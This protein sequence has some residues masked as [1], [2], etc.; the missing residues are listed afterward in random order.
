MNKNKHSKKA[1]DVLRE[2]KF[3]RKRNEF[4][5]FI[6]DWKDWKEYIMSHHRYLRDHY[7]DPELK[8]LGI[9]IECQG[10]AQK[11]VDKATRL[12][13]ETDREFPRQFARDAFGVEL[14][15]SFRDDL[16]HAYFD[17]RH[18]LVETLIITKLAYS[19]TAFDPFGIL[20]FRTEEEQRALLA[21]DGV[22]PDD[23]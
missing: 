22:N 8:I 17:L 11:K 18:E 4:S 15:L 14:L 12:M 3:R 19:S 13:K 23:V 21:E 6:E 2:N 5:K 10:E 20:F 9:V 16:A 7:F 1:L